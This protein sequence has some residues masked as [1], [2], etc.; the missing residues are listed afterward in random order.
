MYEIQLFGRL[1][2]RTRGV[3]LSGSDLGGAEPRQILALLALH[4]EMRTSELTELLW[5]G[6]GHEDKVEGHLSLLRHRLDPG[7]DA[8]DSVIT[9]TPGGYALV[10]DRVRVDVARFDELVAAASGRTA[11]R[12]LRPLTAAGH[13]AARPLLEDVELPRWAAEVRERYRRRL[14]EAVLDAG[15]R[16]LTAGDLRTAR[17]LAE[18]VLELDPQCPMGRALADAARAAGEAHHEPAHGTAAFAA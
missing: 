9:A 5:G 10:A 6:P 13:L 2:V 1:E 8:G 16:A 17:C 7:G 11:S 18:Q 4:G 14:V 3:R 15:R 12:A